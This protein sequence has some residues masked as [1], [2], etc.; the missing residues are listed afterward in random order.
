M[1]FNDNNIKQQ[2]HANKYAYEY[3]NPFV[4]Y[5]ELKTLIKYSESVLINGNRIYLN[6]WLA[7][8]NNN[9]NNNKSDENDYANS[10]TMFTFVK[11][12][13]AIYIK[14]LTENIYNV[15]KYNPRE[16]DRNCDVQK[17]SDF[18]S[19][20]P[21]LKKVISLAITSLFEISDN[22]A[23]LKSLEPYFVKT[24]L[25]RYISMWTANF[26]KVTKK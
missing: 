5:S 1:A 8:I 7:H 22:Y 20:L 15:L 21:N 6:E 2:V 4:N 9:N 23:N 19:L 11:C 12:E 18:I 25:M 14:T 16:N 24:L 13:C 10:K 3:T 17:C 26:L